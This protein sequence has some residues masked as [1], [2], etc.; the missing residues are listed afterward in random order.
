M[1][2]GQ[3]VKLAVSIF[4]AVLLGLA[5]VAAY[6]YFFGSFR[7]S[8]SPVIKNKASLERY[9]DVSGLFPKPLK[10]TPQYGSVPVTRL[11][12]VPQTKFVVTG[13][14]VSGRAGSDG[15]FCFDEV[16]QNGHMSINIYPNPQSEA[17]GKDKLLNLGVLAILESRFGISPDK[18]N[19]FVDH[20]EDNLIFIW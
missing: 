15:L 18:K 10:T 2:L 19:V 5:G 11:A 17:T 12:I 1:E 14:C 6:L 3:K 8:Q 4:L 7:I 20:G 9:L 16:V 13:D